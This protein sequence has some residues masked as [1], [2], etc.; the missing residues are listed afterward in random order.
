MLGAVNKRAI[1]KTKI[2]NKDLPVA[3]FTVDRRETEKN[4]T[5]LLR[6]SASPSHVAVRAS[7]VDKDQLEVLEA[8]IQNAVDKLA[9]IAFAVIDGRDDA[10]LRRDS[11]S[12][13]RRDWNPPPALRPDSIKRLSALSSASSSNTSKRRQILLGDRVKKLVV[14]KRDDYKVTTITIQ[15]I[16]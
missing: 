13:W 3:F 6:R 4:A 10:D 8:L 9:Q 16:I 5:A 7:V 15:R 11:F 14:R 1:K 2:R 12:P